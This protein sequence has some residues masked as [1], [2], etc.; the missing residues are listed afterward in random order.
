[1]IKETA[2]RVERIA[3]ES[4]A[5][6][7][8][9][10]LSTTAGESSLLVCLQCILTCSS[11]R[12]HPMISVVSRYSSLLTHDLRHAV[13]FQRI[14]AQLHLPG[15]A[16]HLPAVS[17]IMSWHSSRYAW[18]LR[19]AVVFQSLAMRESVADRGCAVQEGCRITTRPGSAVSQH[20]FIF[21]FSSSSWSCIDSFTSRHS[22]QPTLVCIFVMF[23][24]NFICPLL[25]SYFSFSPH[26][27]DLL[28]A[29]GVPSRREATP[30]PCSRLVS[31]SRHHRDT[32][33]L[34]RNLFLD[35]PRHSPPCLPPLPSHSFFS[36]L[37]QLSS[38]EI[39]VS[40]S[41]GIAPEDVEEGVVEG[42]AAVGVVGLVSLH[43]LSMSGSHSQSPTGATIRRFEESV[44][45][46]LA[47]IQ[48]VCFIFFKVA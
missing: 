31:A 29:G 11:M 21:L 16:Y 35:I 14:S 42:L 40:G 48:K 19:H 2:E 18:M 9:L 41:Y 15:S 33:L 6:R 23:Q 12:R 24:L 43:Q 46:R 38:T 5:A 26:R 22:L 37:I 27:Q 44:V 45:A 3:L 10:Y 20:G 4:M 8:I 39:I 47:C 32:H 34:V 30:S 25:S 17:F 1:M 36:E 7:A 28:L 13:V